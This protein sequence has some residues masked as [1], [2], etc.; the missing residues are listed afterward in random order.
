LSDGISFRFKAFLVI[1]PK[2]RGHQSRQNTD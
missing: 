1:L 2:L